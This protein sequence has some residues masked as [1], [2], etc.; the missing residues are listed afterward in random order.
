[1]ASENLQK[2]RISP[3]C[4]RLLNDVKIPPENL[5]SFYS[6]YKLPKNAF[7]PWFL[8][9]KSQWLEKRAQWLEERR[10]A[11]LATIKTLPEHR[12][13]A[14]RIL[15]EYEKR[16]NRFGDY[17]LWENRLY[18]KT[19]KRAGE[20]L[21]FGEAEWHALWHNHLIQLSM[22]YRNIPPL[23]DEDGNPTYS[24]R[25]LAALVLRCHRV[26]RK[27]IGD[28]FRRLSKEFHPDRGGNAEQFHNIMAARDV[29]LSQ[30]GES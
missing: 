11:I 9:A 24:A 13:K 30:V 27:E 7:F 22:K 20:L 25:V 8:A 28:N 2:L 14:L 19:K 4:Y 6:A 15:A 18:P 1:M 10:K 29:L 26:D 16:T 23:E 12:R 17:P 5:K 21:R 3:R